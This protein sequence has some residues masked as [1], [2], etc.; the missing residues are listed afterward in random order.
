MSLSDVSTLVAQ[1]GYLATF[2]TVLLASAGI[3]IP[4]G[5]VLIAAAAYAAQTHRLSLP[6]LILVGSAGAVLGGAAGFGLGRTVG[7]R[8]LRRFGGRVGLS[9]ARIRLGEYLFRLHGGK[10]VFALRFTALLGPFGGVLAGVNRMPISRFM[11]F[12]V[13]GGIAW[14]LVFGGGGYLF[15]AVFKA[16]GRSAGLAATGLAVALV[17]AL[18]LYL[19]RREAELQKRADAMLCP[20]GAAPIGE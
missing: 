3:P 15:S 10:I 16:V 4:A 17:I 6:V 14:T 9:A 18:F 5:E 8:T 7:V 1:Y 19:R 20:E 12:N 11:V 13:L 2:T